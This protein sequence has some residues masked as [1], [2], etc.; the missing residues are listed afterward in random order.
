MFIRWFI[1]MYE[2]SIFSCSTIPKKKLSWRHLNWWFC[3]ILRSK[4]NKKISPFKQV[5]KLSLSCQL[6]KILN[7][8]EVITSHNLNL[9]SQEWPHFL[10][11]CM[12]RECP[13]IIDY[14]WNLKLRSYLPKTTKKLSKLCLHIVTLELPSSIAEEA[15]WKRRKKK[16]VVLQAEQWNLSSPTW[17]MEQLI[18]NAQLMKSQ[19]IAHKKGDLDFN[20]KKATVKV[21][22]E[23][24]ISIGFWI[25]EIHNLYIKALIKFYNINNFV[26]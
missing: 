20:L 13:S 4:Q 1:R 14:S 15:N 9:T 6:V 19:T 26:F 23:N 17:K 25:N 22:K 16:K 18:K 7:I 21:S 3:L 5:D 11:L 24:L 12:N 2:K 8:N 10:K